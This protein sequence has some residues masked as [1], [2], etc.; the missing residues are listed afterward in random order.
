[1]PPIPADAASQIDLFGWILLLFALAIS[2]LWGAL[3]YGSSQVFK[4]MKEQAELARVA[5]EQADERERAERKRAADEREALSAH[6]RH[7]REELRRSLDLHTDESRK[8]TDTLIKMAEHP[9]S[10]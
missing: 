10:H 8:I 7:E 9:P 2:A 1:M 5:K 3:F 4:W 6:Y